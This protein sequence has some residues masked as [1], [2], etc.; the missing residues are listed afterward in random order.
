MGYQRWKVTQLCE[1]KRI[2]PS[3]V[4]VCVIYVWGVV[5]DV[6]YTNIWLAM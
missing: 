4:I 2:Q 1:N 3:L 5:K 6:S